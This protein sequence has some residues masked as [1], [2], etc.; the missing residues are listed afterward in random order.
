M[1]D[2][3]LPKVT[4]AMLR[5]SESMCG[6]RLSHEHA[7]H[8]SNRLGTGRF[9]L[10]NQ[11][12]EHA[13]VAQLELGP[14]RAAAFQPLGLEP[15]EVRVY[16]HAAATYLQLFGDRRARSIDL[17]AWETLVPEHGVRLVGGGGLPF[18]DEHGAR[19]LRFLS[20]R[21]ND[22][23][24]A[25]PLR[26]VDARFAILRHAAWVA[27]AT[28]R[29]VHVDLLYSEL[30]EHFVDADGCLRELRTWL[31]ERVQVLRDQ[32]EEARPRVGLECGRCRYVVRCPAH[33]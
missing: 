19:E 30:V 2:D 26:S 28:V 13:R 11:I 18:E 14:P 8:R 33:G 7:N 12:V 16:E 24:P 29:L 27:G 9:R 15:E 23:D 25:D 10:A 6:F 32:I 1:L 17:D 4:A 20:L 31:R 3:D 22:A 5:R 21:P